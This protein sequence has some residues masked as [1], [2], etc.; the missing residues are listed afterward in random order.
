MLNQKID[1]LNI[2]IN[3]MNKLHFFTIKYKKHIKVIKIFL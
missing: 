3:I 1:K 2:I